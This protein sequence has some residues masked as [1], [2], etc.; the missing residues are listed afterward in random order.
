MLFMF[1]F[2]YKNMVRPHN[3]ALKTENIKSIIR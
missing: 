2:S 1:A 3:A